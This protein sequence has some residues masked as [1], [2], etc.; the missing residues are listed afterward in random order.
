MEMYIINVLRPANDVVQ[1]A[2]FF[3]DTPEPNLEYVMV[4]IRVTCNKPGNERCLFSTVV[5]K[6]V[7]KDGQVRDQPYA[8]DIPE[9]L[10]AP[11]DFFGGDSV[12]GNLVFLV[13][14]EDHSAVLYFDPLYIDNPTY[15]ALQ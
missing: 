4:M 10:E 6:T 9:F 11:A 14:Q 1:H 12:E 5:F 2:H 7:G 13:P 15:I 3:N 8:D